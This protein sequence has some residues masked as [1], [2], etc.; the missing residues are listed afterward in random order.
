MNNKNNSSS[1]SERRAVQ[2][3]SRGVLQKLE[4]EAR[5]PNQFVR[6]VTLNDA[7]NELYLHRTLINDTTPIGKCAILT[8]KGILF[9]GSA[10]SHD[11][12]YYSRLD[13]LPIN[14]NV[15]WKTD[16]GIE[17]NVLREFLSIL[18][19]K[20]N[21]YIGLT[22]M[23]VC[24]CQDPSDAWRSINLKLR[25]SRGK[26]LVKHTG[27][28]VYAIINMQRLGYGISL[29]TPGHPRVGRKGGIYLNGGEL[30]LVTCDRKVPLH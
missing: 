27:F 17:S 28:K 25:T 8:N 22:G 19:D 1:S 5:D 15:N 29:N 20:T 21:G 6:R 14:D 26:E 7:E 24:E 4:T 18:D 9:D 16:I 23:A 12:N 10:L 3:D 13:N 30:V 2:A 11:G